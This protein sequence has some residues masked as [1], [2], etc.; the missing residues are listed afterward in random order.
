MNLDFIKELLCLFHSNHIVKL[1]EKSPTKYR[2]RTALSISLSTFLFCVCLAHARQQGLG[3]PAANGVAL[4]ADSITPLQIG[5]T[6]PDA[7]WN[8]PLQV[9]NHPQ[10]KET[11]KLADYSDKLIILDFWA[12]WCGSCI[13]N[14]PKLAALQNDNEKHVK[15]LLV[16]S[17]STRDTR[18]KAEQFLS[19]RQKEYNLTSIVADTVLKKLFPHRSIP[20]YVWINGGRYLAATNGEDL[21]DGNVQNTFDGKDIQTSYVPETEYNIRQPLF[22]NGNGGEAPKYIYKSILAPFVNGLKSSF[23][24]DRDNK[25]LISRVAFTNARLSMIYSYAYPEIQNLSKARLVIDVENPEPF[26]SG[27]TSLNWKHK[28][29]YNYEAQ[30][31][32]TSEQNA[33]KIVRHDLQKFFGYILRSE[34]RVLDCWVVKSGNG[35][36][37]TDFPNNLKSETNL[38]DNDGTDIYFNNYPLSNLLNELERLYGQPFLDETGIGTPVKLNLPADLLQKHEVQTSLLKQGIILTKEKRELPVVILSDN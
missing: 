33:K 13:K 23:S 12:T 3:A 38:Y 11:I 35:S 29:L 30:F 2:R 27:N 20:H 14:F 16:N 36:I 21:T 9:V 5:D 24:T 8:L 28:N 10:G 32:P 22:E 1:S 7:L 4:S 17:R 25:R 34:N 6:I 37:A 15:T 31:P 18:N 19:K 26:E